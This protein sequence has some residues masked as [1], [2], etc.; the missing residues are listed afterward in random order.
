MSDN[1]DFYQLSSM[2]TKEEE[3]SK[4]LLI[5][6]VFGHLMI[7]LPSEQADQGGEVLVTYQDGS[8]RRCYKPSTTA[9]FQSVYAS[10]RTEAKCEVAA[11]EKGFRIGL[12]YDLVLIRDVHLDPPTP[13]VSKLV[14]VATERLWEWMLDEKLNEKVFDRKHQF[15]CVLLTCSN[16]RSY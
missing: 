13:A 4:H 10:F 6:K 14:S 2:L 7:S 16:R 15:I 1:A 5:R 12:V 11:V 8:Q 3:S 9:Q